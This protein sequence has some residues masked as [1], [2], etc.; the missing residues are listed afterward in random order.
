VHL[1]PS[2]RQFLFD[3]MI[4]RYNE[5]FEKMQ[6]AMRKLIQD[7]VK[8]MELDEHK[9]YDIQGSPSGWMLVERKPPETDSDRP[10]KRD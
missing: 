2:D 5:T 10:G 8:E 3:A 7:T 9:M 4:T 6:S 1:I